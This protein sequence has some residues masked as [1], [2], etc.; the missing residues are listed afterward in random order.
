MKTTRTLL[1][2]LLLI[3]ISCDKEEVA[4]TSGC[5]PVSLVTALCGN[6][7]LKIEDPSF[8]GLG[9]NVDG[10]ENVFLAQ[11]DC[12]VYDQVLTGHSFL[13]RLNPDDFN[14]QCAN[15]LALLQ[16]SGSKKYNVQICSDTVPEK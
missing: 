6:G 11:F 2:C 9:E 12:F 8:Y 4:N 16:Y 5:V 7:I 15:C 3:V 10:Y 14:D 13:V 1:F